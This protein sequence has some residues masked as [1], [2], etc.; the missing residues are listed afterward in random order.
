MTVGELL[1]QLLQATTEGGLPESA[2][3]TVL[4]DKGNVGTLSRCLVT[5]ENKSQ[6]AGIVLLGKAP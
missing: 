6:V 4:V 1:M 3:V 5:V 2:E